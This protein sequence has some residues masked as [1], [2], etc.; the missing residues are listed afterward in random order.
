ME[1]KLQRISLF[2][3]TE[4]QKKAIR[5]VLA[6]LDADF[7]MDRLI[8]GDVSFGKTEV[9]LRA[10]LRAVANG[11][12]VAFL[13]PTTILALQ[14]FRN[15]ERRLAD[16]P[17]RLAMLSRLVGQAEKKR[18]RRRAR[19][20]RRSTWSSA[21]I[22]CWPRGWNSRTWGCSSSTRSSASACSRRKS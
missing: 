12:Q 10:A 7:P 11:S 20:R 8:C 22:R 13:C 6:D 21:P 19:E 14:H 1:E 2:V 18:D 9:A 15:F 16:F 4:D 5:A 3:E 17:L